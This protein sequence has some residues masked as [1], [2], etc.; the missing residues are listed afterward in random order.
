MTNDG[1][2]ALAYDA[3]N[4]L[5]TS[6][7]SNY[8]Y[9]GNGLRVKKVSGGTTTVYI[10]SDRKVIAEYDNGAA[11]GSPSRE[12]IYSGAGLLATIEGSTTKYHH[13]D[14]LSVR[15]TTD[16]SGNLMGQQGHYPFGESWY[17][18]ST[19]TKWQFTSYERDTESGND[20]AVFRYLVNR[21]G[22][23]S[24]PDQ[25]GGSTTN[26]QSLNRYAYVANN[27][28]NKRDHNGL[29]MD[30]CGD[31]PDCGG[32]GD[33]GG[34]DGGGGDGGG[35][36]GGDSGKN[37]GEP[38]QDENGCWSDDPCAPEDT[39]QENPGIPAENLCALLN[40]CGQEPPVPPMVIQIFPKEVARA[41]KLAAAKDCADF[42]KK[43]QQ[44]AIALAVAEA[45]LSASNPAAQYMQSYADNF[46]A[47]AAAV[48][49]GLAYAVQQPNV[50]PV[51]DGLRTVAT[52]DR[53]NPSITFFQAFYS[54]NLTGR[55]QTLLHEGSHLYF[56]A[57]DQQLA[58]AAAVPASDRDTV[59]KASM[60][61]EKELE[62]HCK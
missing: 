8:S 42:L 45:Q 14:H 55:A 58:Q 48:D 61:F 33:G 40:I 6:S 38:T 18:A 29:T 30:D 46:T 4:G 32:G 62:K 21:L 49:A 39:Q 24:S 22:R 35:E 16:S 23:F 53:G 43:I 5:V 10:F 41:L 7:G 15:A 50:N 17:S 1:L 47:S 2:N 13:A 54:S 12:Y 51:S 19:T 44:G 28:V 27:P 31:D 9:D 57:T 37:S 20:Y 26:P 56:G 25:L 59:G 34:G 60:N 52:A 3:Q 11:V 36:D